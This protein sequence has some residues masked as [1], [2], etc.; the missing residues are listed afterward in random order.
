MWKRTSRPGASRFTHRGEGQR[1]PQPRLARPP[2]GGRPTALGQADG[3]RHRPRDHGRR[4]SGNRPSGTLPGSGRASGPAAGP[5]TGRER[6]PHQGEQAPGTEPHVWI[7]GQAFAPL[8]A[9]QQE[10]RPAP[11]GYSGTRATDPRP[12]TRATVPA[13][14]APPSRTARDGRTSA[15]A[16]SP[17]RKGRPPGNHGPEAGFA[18]GAKPSPQARLTRGPRG[19]TQAW[20]GR[21]CQRRPTALPGAAHGRAGG[22]NRHGGGRRSRFPGDRTDDARRLL[23][24]PSAR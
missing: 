7:A 2:P 9:Q 3:D 1:R 21:T 14:Q 15:K 23:G 12:R 8:L 11:T 13:D 20:P 19:R 16:P 17:V 24:S 6:R 5:G 10:H 18:P 22:P 4:T